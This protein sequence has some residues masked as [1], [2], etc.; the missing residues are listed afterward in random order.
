MDHPVF[1]ADQPTPIATTHQRDNPLSGWIEELLSLNVNKVL[2]GGKSLISPN[3]DQSAWDF[4]VIGIR[5]ER[6]I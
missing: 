2:R 1:R 6:K 3:V 5:D 4:D